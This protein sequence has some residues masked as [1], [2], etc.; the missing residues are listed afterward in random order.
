MRS[1]KDCSEF[2]YKISTVCYFEVFKDGSVDQIYVDGKQYAQDAL[3][4]CDRVIS[5]ESVLYAVWPGQWHSDIFI[6]DD[7]ELFRQAMIDITLG[8]KW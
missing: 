2:P 5:G 7:I 4:V 6:I 3:K 1:A 8:K